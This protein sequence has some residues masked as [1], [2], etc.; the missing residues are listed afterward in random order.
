METNKHY[1][2]HD[3]KWLCGEGDIVKIIEAKPSSKT[4]RWAVLEVVDKAK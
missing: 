2:A 4:K 3:E 1:N